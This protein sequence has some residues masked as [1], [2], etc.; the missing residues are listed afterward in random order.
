MIKNT[1]D[2]S[3]PTKPALKSLLS[4]SKNLHLLLLSKPLH[5]TISKHV[6][7]RVLSRL[8]TTRLVLVAIA[9]VLI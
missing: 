6:I 8:A 9:F 4:Q 1:P 2:V 7:I 5:P 3:R